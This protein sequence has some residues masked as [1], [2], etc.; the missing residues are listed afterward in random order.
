MKPFPILV[1][2]SCKWHIGI[3][4]FSSRRWTILRVVEL[5]AMAEESAW[6]GSAHVRKLVHVGRE[7]MRKLNRGLSN[8]GCASQD[9][10]VRRLP[11][12]SDNAEYVFI[13]FTGLYVASYVAC[14]SMSQLVCRVSRLVMWAASATEELP[15]RETRMPSSL[16]INSGDVVFFSVEGA[17]RV[18]SLC[19]Y[20]L[21]RV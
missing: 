2:N 7:E 6:L 11:R 4:S 16:L 10:L 3:M 14:C 9:A 21:L 1:F 12:V 15:S 18:P 20:L 5:Y 17:M 8:L 19:L 13:G